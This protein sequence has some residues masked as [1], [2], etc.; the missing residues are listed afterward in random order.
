[1]AAKTYDVA[2]IGAG[3]GGYV[4]AIRAAQLGLTTVVDRARA[5]R[6]HLPELG[7]HPDQGAAALLRDLP[8]DAP[9]QGVRAQGR[10]R[11]LRPRRGGQALAR[12][13]QAAQSGG[14]G[15]PDEEEQDRRGDGRGDARRPR[16]R[17]ASRP[18]RAPRRSRPRR[19][20][21][22]PAPAP[23]TCPGSRPT[24]SGSGTTSTRWC[25]RTCRRS[26][27]SSARAPSASS[28]RAST[29]R[30]APRRRWS[31]CSTAS[32]RSRTPRSRPSPRSSSRSRR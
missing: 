24:A 3:P 15:H 19:S 14:V 1:M 10:E 18:T 2:V 4:A 32:C 16:A 23:A 8:P 29:T 11:R 28:S 21:S 30:S 9:R 5:P 26:C 17:S 13:R 6:R 7:L 22:P 27:S 20:S 25:R 12:G 31:R